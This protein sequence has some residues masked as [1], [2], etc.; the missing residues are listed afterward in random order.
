MLS[1]FGVLAGLEEMSAVKE[2]SSVAA[3]PR[4]RLSC[5]TYFDA[6]MFCYCKSTLD[7]LCYVSMYI[8]SF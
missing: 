4:K 1:E 5:T 6:L 2:E 7:P 3:A 8:N